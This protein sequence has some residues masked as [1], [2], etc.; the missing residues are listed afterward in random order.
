MDPHIVV[1]DYGC[2]EYK[3]NTLYDAKIYWALF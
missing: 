1:R 3:N 2:W